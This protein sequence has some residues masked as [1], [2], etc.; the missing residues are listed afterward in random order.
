MVLEKLQEALA[1]IA[2]ERKR[3]DDAEV[4]LRAAISGLIGEP[5]LKSVPVRTPETFATQTVA[6]NSPVQ[7]PTHIEV[8]AGILKAEGKPMHINAIVK[9]LA[10][11][12]GNK[13]LK[14]NAIEPGVTRHISKV[15]QPAIAKFGPST[16]GL[17]EWNRPQ[18][19]E[20]L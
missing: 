20:L 4:S 16:Y 11:V 5:V 18:Q 14:R 10:V 12:Y 7:K 19:Q 9:R 6:Q 13:D 3:L 8:I 1:E 17:P 15:K 2:R